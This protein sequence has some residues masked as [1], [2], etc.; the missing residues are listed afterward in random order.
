MLFK[1]SIIP[2]PHSFKIHLLYI[3]VSLAYYFLQK[4]EILNNKKQDERAENKLMYT[5]FVFRILCNVFSVYLVSYSRIISSYSSSDS[6]LQ[7]LP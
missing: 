5:H 7:H 1:I 3:L 4:C 2:F 6:I